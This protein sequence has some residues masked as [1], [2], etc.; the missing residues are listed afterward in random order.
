MLLDQLL[1]RAI[2]NDYEKRTHETESSMSDNT[3]YVKKTLGQ[4]DGYCGDK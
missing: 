2:A 1:E 3:K 4:I